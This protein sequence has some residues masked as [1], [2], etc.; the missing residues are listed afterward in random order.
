[1]E[2]KTAGQKRKAAA[3]GA[4][5]SA[6]AAKQPRQWWEEEQAH[7]ADDDDDVAYYR[8]EARPAA[9]PGAARGFKRVPMSSRRGAPSLSQAACCRAPRTAQRTRWLHG[10]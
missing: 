9:C 7:A 4:E 1:M 2:R 8:E 10:L 6:S 5:G 3:A